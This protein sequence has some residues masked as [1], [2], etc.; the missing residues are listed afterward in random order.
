M[1]VLLTYCRAVVSTS[2]LIAPRQ[3]AVDYAQTLR[4]QKRAVCMYRPFAGIVIS[5]AR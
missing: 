4:A 2:F 5:P 3:A 1:S